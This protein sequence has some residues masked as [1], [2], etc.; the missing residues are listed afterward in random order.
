MIGKNYNDEGRCD[1]LWVEGA[2]GRLNYSTEEQDVQPKAD[3]GIGVFL[4]P[5]ALVGLL[6]YMAVKLTG[7]SF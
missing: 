6:V 1:N 2:R 7:H 4:I 5:L 3:P